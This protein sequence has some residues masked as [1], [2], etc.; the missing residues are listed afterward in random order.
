MIVTGGAEE[1]ITVQI[2]KAKYLSMSLSGLESKGPLPQGKL[3]DIQL[4][5]NQVD[6]YTGR[7]LGT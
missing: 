2:R 6:S 5:S 4:V 7:K 3:D 1:D